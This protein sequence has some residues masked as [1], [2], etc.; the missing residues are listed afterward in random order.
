MPASPLEPGQARLDQVHLLA[1]IV[2]S[3]EDAIA[4]KTLDGVLTS[5]NRAAEKLFGY[6]ADEAIGQSVRMLIPHD[7]QS[8]EEMILGKIRRGERIEHYE[9]IRVRKD[10]T[11]IE[12]AVT[13]S[14]VRD[15]DGEIVGASKIVRDIAERKRIEQE[16]RRLLEREHQARVEAETL[17]RLALSLTAELDLE[18]LLQGVTDAGREL[19]DAQFAAFFYDEVTEAGD[20]HVLFTLSGI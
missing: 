15:S 14:P 5:W 3:S 20:A 12:V 7:R 1:S 11:P 4:S 9:T 8:E 19:T 13:I 17:R 6:T 2:E 18:R 10:G 16:R